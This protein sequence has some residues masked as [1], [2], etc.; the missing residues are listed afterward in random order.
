MD[1]NNDLTQ[2]IEDME[3]KREAVVEAFDELDIEVYEG[4]KLR[5]V[6]NCVSGKYMDELAG[7]NA[8]NDFPDGFGVQVSLVD[9]A[10]RSGASVMR[11]EG[12]WELK[13]HNWTAYQKYTSKK[14]YDSFEEPVRMA[15]EYTALGII[16]EKEVSLNSSG[17]EF[18]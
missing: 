17:L 12:K 3:L 13:L 8:I 1:E 14:L 6:G 4:V 7:V 9:S 16:P 5:Y 2:K 15:K 18:D 11:K 10:N